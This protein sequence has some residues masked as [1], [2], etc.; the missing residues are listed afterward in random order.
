M[1]ICLFQDRPEH[2]VSVQ[3]ALLSLRTFAPDWPV[4]VYLAHEDAAF[5]AWLGQFDNV[6]LQRAVARR[7]GYNAKPAVILDMLDRYGE[8]VLWIDSDIVLTRPVSDILARAPAGAVIV[9][10]DP[11]GLWPSGTEPRTRGW[12]FPLGRSLETSV[13]SCIVGVDPTHRPLVEAW[14]A[15]LAS[16]T[17]NQA[18][19]EHW[20]CRP[21]Y[22]LGDQDALA[23]L[24]G[25]AAFAHL[26][27]HALKS[28]S[29]IA[30]CYFANGYSWQDRL[31]NLVRGRPAF[32]H[33]QGQKPWDPP[34]PL[35]IYLD[36][37]PYKF[38]AR[39]Y[40]PAL[41]QQDWLEVRTGA[42]RALTLL[43]LGHPDLSG[44][45]PAMLDS[46][47]MTVRR[48]R[49]KTRLLGAP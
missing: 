18:Q 41:L 13:N 3:L 44:L 10:E 37:S 17:Y 12:G 14:V 48:L 36:V 34:S 21:F 5:E 31:L 39:S 9:A 1:R 30:Q 28:G 19:A 47:R 16:E 26:A 33:A 27:V 43:A 15:A 20:S 35:P 32:V 11:P 38:H 46:A 7:N 45:L 25:S 23:A 24:L 6:A 22:F 2:F 29:E 42:G 8:K 40:G 4:D 49:K